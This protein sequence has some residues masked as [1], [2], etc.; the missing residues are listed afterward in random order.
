MKDMTLGEIAAKLNLSLSTVS[1][2]INNKSNVGAQTR[3]RV[4]RFLREQDCLQLIL[5][6]GLLDHNEV[7]AV[8]IPDISEDYFDYVVRGIE[9]HL[10]KEHIGM[11]LCDT[12][13]DVEKEAQFMNMLIGKNFTG[14]ILATVDKNEKQLAGY[15][16]SG[17][18]LVFFDNLPNINLTFNSVLTDNVKA[19][20]LAVNHLLNLGHR[21]IGFISGKQE[22]TTGF[23]RLVG[24]R[25]AL[26]LRKIEAAE[27]L[28]AYGDFKE[29]SGYQ[30]M[31][32]L[33]DANPALSAVFVS[34]A[35]MTYG[36]LKALN[37][38]GLRVPEDIALVGFDIHDKTGLIRPGITSIMQSEE[39][40]GQLCV[41]LLRRSK[42]ERGLGIKSQNQRIQLEPQLVIRGSCGAP[43]NH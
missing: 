22:E 15:L 11:L 27:S 33:L 43:L 26:E 39:H 6:Q 38:R 19:G 29:A 34:S 21:C 32:K 8:V 28:I 23:E 10:W 30:G 36:A 31:M 14:I 4:I 1:R 12:M 17:I 35:K 5:S 18:N 25:R 13:E 37:D 2:V 40:I 9:K 42:Q 7:V 24:Y 16:Q 3:E 41:E 20:M